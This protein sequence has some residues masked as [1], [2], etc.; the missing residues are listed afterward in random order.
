VIDIQYCDSLIVF[1]RHPV[2]NCMLFSI[3]CS[4]RDF[5]VSSGRIIEGSPADR[6][7]QL[8]VGDRIVSVNG[9]NI[10][11]MH[12]GDIVNLI[13][14]SGNTV[15]LTVGAPE[16]GEFVSR[17]CSNPVT[18]V[19]LCKHICPRFDVRDG[20]SVWWDFRWCRSSFFG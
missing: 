6:C 10:L 5:L 1:N 3:M 2:C 8:H 11:Q 13:K 16:E 9:I 15:T 12:H 17:L 4:T 14:D 19:T 18:D 20:K 7:G